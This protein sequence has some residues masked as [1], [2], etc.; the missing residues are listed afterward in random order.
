MT[1]WFSKNEIEK[2]EKKIWFS[3]DHHFGHANIIKYCNRPFGS[4]AHMDEALIHLWNE[5]VGPDDKVYYL[6]DF[7]LARIEYIEPIVQ[8]LNGKK[9]L[10]HG[11]HD[12]TFPTSKKPTP[13]SRYIDIGFEEVCLEKLITLPL[14]GV[15]QQV[16]LSHL[17]YAPLDPTEEVDRRYLHMRPKDEGHL[18]LHGHIHQHW[19]K[20]QCG[21]MINVG[22]DVWDYKPISISE[23]EQ[24]L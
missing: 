17:P 23:I 18:L 16:K 6:G 12:R 9:I 15:A 19:K 8:R 13:I 3:S 10:V 20:S 1:I 11:N 24:C 4:V 5:V 21:R 14:H 22:V 2:K 7:S